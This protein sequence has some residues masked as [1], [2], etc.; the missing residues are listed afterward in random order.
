MERPQGRR[1]PAE[2]G[3][4][5]ATGAFGSPA[6][7]LD[8]TSV[9]PARRC[10]G[11]GGHRI[12][13]GD[14]PVREDVGAQAAAV[15]QAAQHPALGQLRELV[16]RLAELDALALDPADAEAPADERVEVD[17]AG[18]HVA[19]RR[20]VG[21]LDPGVLA[22]PLER[23]GRDQRER[24]PGPGLVRAVVLALEG[25]ARERGDALDRRRQRT[26]LLRDRDL[27]DDAAHAA[28]VP[29]ADR[30]PAASTSA[31]NSASWPGSSSKVSACHWTPRRNGWPGSSSASIVPS[32]AHA[33]AT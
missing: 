22:Q 2:T 8:R 29:G 7:G 6:A 20:L 9:Q 16:A 30:R 23:L 13:D 27:L 28:S 15:D 10:S 24:L 31:A 1:G 14:L 33:V 32:A 5:S 17:A 18:E 21:E 4:G 11:R 25:A 12:A 19:A 3:T 26:A